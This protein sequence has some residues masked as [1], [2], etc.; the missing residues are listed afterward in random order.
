[1]KNKRKTHKQTNNQQTQA[2]EKETKTTNQ[3]TSKYYL[4]TQ[5]T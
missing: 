2:N 1:M 3:S 5:H 4:K